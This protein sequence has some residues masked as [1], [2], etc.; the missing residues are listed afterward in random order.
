MSWFC[1]QLELF[2]KA[3]CKIWSVTG[4]AKL[5]VCRAVSDLYLPQMKVGTHDVNSQKASV[6][7]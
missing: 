6:C 7:L 3:L 2:V 5:D 1:Q 4:F